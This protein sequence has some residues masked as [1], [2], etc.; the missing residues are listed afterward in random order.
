MSWISLF[1]FLL[2]VVLFLFFFQFIRKL[3]ICSLISFL[4]EWVLANCEW[5]ILLWT[6]QFHDSSLFRF[7]SSLHQLLK[8]NKIGSISLT[9]QFSSNTSLF[10]ENSHRDLSF[11]NSRQLVSSLHFAPPFWSYE[12]LKS[13]FSCAFSCLQFD[14]DQEVT[15]TIQSRKTCIY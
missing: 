1:F 13:E 15:G 9:E 4:F 7:F 14:I 2:L 3:S 11:L 8:R 6:S 5:K 12:R 10:M